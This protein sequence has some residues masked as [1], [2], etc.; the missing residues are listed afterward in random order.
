MKKLGVITLFL[1]TVLVLSVVLSVNAITETL[2]QKQEGNQTCQNILVYSPTGQ[3][4]TPTI[5][6]LSAVEIYFRTYEAPGTLTVNI[7]ESTIDG[8]I[9]GTASKLMS[10]V[11]DGWLRFDFPGGIALTP[12]SLYVIEVNTDASNFLW[13][14]QGQNPYPGGRYIM[15]GIPDESADKAF[16]TYASAPVGGVVLPINKLVIL[17]PYMAIAGLIIAVSAVYVMRRRKN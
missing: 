12:G 10:D 5:S 14:A 3:E 6:P 1:T 13:C 17:T 4:F 2:D 9:L 7:R 15:E 8:T 11:F 16:R